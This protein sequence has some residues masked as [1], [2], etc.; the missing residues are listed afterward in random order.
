[1]KIHES[2][3]ELTA[4]RPSQEEEQSWLVL[5]KRLRSD[6]VLLHSTEPNLGYL[7]EEH[8]A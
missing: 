6:N 8:V 5:P 2:G 7:L 1:M 4:A 3:M